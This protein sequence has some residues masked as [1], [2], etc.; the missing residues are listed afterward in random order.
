MPYVTSW[1]RMAK[2]EGKKIGNERGVRIGEEKGDRNARLE[3]AKQMMLENFPMDTIVKL[4]GLPLTELTDLSK[5][6]SQRDYKADKKLR[7]S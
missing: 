6:L 5:S 4:T 3:V 1:E 2:E 7:K